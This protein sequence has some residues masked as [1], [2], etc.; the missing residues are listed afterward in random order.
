MYLAPWTIAA[1]ENVSRPSGFL[2][3]HRGARGAS[4]KRRARFKTQ[5]EPQDGPTEPQGSRTAHHRSHLLLF[6]VN[7]ALFPLK[8]NK[9]AL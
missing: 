5:D 2:C 3:P 4:R 8:T 1:R 7:L 9:G 6:Q